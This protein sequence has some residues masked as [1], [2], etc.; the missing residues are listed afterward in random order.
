MLKNTRFP[1]DIPYVCFMYK[2]VSLQSLKTNSVC[3]KYLREYTR[4]YSIRTN[5]K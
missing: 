5:L 1:N 4:V 3:R 2:T